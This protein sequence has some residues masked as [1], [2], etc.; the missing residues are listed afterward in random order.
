M[1]MHLRLALHP[2]ERL[3]TQDATRAPRSPRPASSSN[4]A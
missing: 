3:A 2:F 4:R 1:R